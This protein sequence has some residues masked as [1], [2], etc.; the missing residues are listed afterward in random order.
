MLDL[1]LSI[2]VVETP[3]SSLTV[4]A[5]VRHQGPA[6]PFEIRVRTRDNSRQ[7]WTYVEGVNYFPRHAR[8]SAVGRKVTVRL[9]PGLK[10]QS[11]LC[12]WSPAPPS[13]E[14]LS[15]SLSIM[16]CANLPSPSALG[17]TFSF[18]ISDL[19][20]VAWSSAPLRGTLAG[21]VNQND[22]PCHSALVW[23]TRPFSQAS[24]GPTGSIPVTSPLH[25]LLVASCSD[26]RS[27]EHQPTATAF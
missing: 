16:S 1:A 15:V 18:P 7:P 24:T 2:G 26:S 27:D 3:Y 9:P 20:P 23:L 19:K 5:L 12:A 4:R 10:A 11:Q 22:L 6:I 13:Q 21:L 8:T 14:R 25:P 17:S